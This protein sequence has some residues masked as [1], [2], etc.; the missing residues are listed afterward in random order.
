MKTVGR[1]ADLQEAPP[2]GA[3]HARS[4]P[5]ILILELRAAD[6]DVCRRTRPPRRPWCCSDGREGRDCTEGNETGPEAAREP[7]TGLPLRSI[8]SHSSKRRAGV[9]A[10]GRLRPGALARGGSIKYRPGVDGISFTV[11]AVLY[12]NRWIEL[13]WP[14]SMATTTPC[15][16]PSACAT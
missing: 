1:T 6:A 7:P 2:P 9:V 10:V 15:A 12:I 4:S 16:A 11:H 5:E 13:D 14:R 8:K 3:R